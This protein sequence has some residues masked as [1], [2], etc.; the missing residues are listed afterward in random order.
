MSS[1]ASDRM[2]SELRLHN[3]LRSSTAGIASRSTLEAN[4]LTPMP[5]RYHHP[6]VALYITVVLLTSSVEASDYTAAGGC[7]YATKTACIGGCANLRVTTTVP[8]NSGD[9]GCPAAPHPLIFF[10]N[11]LQVTG[12]YITPFKVSSCG[13]CM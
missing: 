3:K 4:T 10:F 9:A 13:S 11:G 2:N 5:L 1:C 8:Q 6:F 12:L 7:Q